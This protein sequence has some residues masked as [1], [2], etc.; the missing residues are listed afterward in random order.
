M[1]EWAYTGSRS[2]SVIPYT[3]C[4]AV[5]RR[6]IQAACAWACVSVALAAIY[7]ASGRPIRLPFVGGVPNSDKILHALAYG[8]LTG[9]WHF[10]LRSTWPECRARRQAFVAAVLAAAYG[11]TDEWHQSFVLGRSATAG[12]W[13]ADL[14]GALLAG[15]LLA[16]LARPGRV[17]E[18]A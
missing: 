17:S 5:T 16:Y 8:V 6:T 18:A 2:E 7:W 1:S 13:L 4:Q 14:V 10:A 12:D 11:A 9:I 3:G 15:V